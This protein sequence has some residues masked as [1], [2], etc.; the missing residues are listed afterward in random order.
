METLLPFGQIPQRLFKKMN[1]KPER[2][3]KK[4]YE[5]TWRWHQQNT[6]G[7]GKYKI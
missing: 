1:W 7:Y 6:I 4:I 5:D 3:I 2:S